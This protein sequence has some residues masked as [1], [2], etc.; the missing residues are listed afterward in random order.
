VLLFW[1]ATLGETRLRVGSLSELAQAPDQLLFDSADFGGP[2]AGEPTQI[3]TESAA[4]FIFNQQR[5]VALRVGA[6]GRATLL[7]Q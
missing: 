5:P 7:G 2:V 3:S 4:L 6:D 1:R